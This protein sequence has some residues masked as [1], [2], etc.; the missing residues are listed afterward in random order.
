VKRAWLV[1]AATAVVASCDSQNDHIFS[2]QQYEPAT[3]CL[4]PSTGID[5]ISGAATGDNCDPV[6]L[7]ITQNGQSYT[8]LSTVCP[9][10]P[11][12]YTTEAADAATDAADPCV[13]AFIAADAGGCIP[14]ACGGDDGGEGG[15]TEAGGDDAGGTGDDGGSAD[16]ASE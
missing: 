13:A 6:C 16:A 3:G 7:S 4:D 11:N 5:V 1:V 8:Y 12:A 14:S 2:A 15:C 9:P 10:Y